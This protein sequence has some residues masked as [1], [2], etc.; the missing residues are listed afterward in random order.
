MWTDRNDEL[1]MKILDEIIPAGGARRMPSAGVKAVAESVLSATAYSDN[2]VE[3][4]TVVLQAVESRAGDFAGLPA[5]ERVALLKLVEADHP[6]PFNELVRLT[7]MA[8][9]S[10]PEIRPLLGVG[11]HPVHPG[12]YEVTRES[13]DLMN[14]LTAPV[15]AR[16]IAYRQV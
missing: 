6:A 10:R 12:G 14:D 15:R 2:P 1:L 11:A 3:S 13:E 9:Y 16:G 7:Y 8:Y 4:V 5:P